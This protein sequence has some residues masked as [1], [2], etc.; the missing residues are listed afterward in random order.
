VDTAVGATIATVA[1]KVLTFLLGDKKGRKFLLYVVGIALFI[2]CLPLIVLVG[3]FGWM[4]GDGGTLI[5]NDAVLSML[6]EQQASQIAVMD[7]TCNTIASVFESKGLDTEDSKKAS[8][9]YI[10]YLVG[11]ENEENFFENLAD[12]FLNTKADKDVYDLVSETFLVVVS[13]EDQSIMDDLYGITP[14]RVTDET[15][16]EA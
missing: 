3:L 2:I 5:D 16:G 6:P 12:C 11:M 15:S 4:A 8:A 14:T 13:E 7:S 9:I 1:K 10:S